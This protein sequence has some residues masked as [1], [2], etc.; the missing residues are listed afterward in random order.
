[1]TELASGTDLVE[2]CF[3]RGWTDGLPVAPPTR[4]RVDAML[5][6]HWNRRDEEVAVLEPSRG[7]ATLEHV[8]ANAVMAGCRPEHLPVVEA[9]VRACADPAFELDRVLTTASSQIP[10]L[11][12]SGPVVEEVG[13]DGGREALGSGA[14]ANA[15][16]GRALMLVLRNVA[17]LT[18]G[19]LPHSTLGHPGA[20]GWCVAENGADSPWP[21][22]HADDG[23]RADR[24]VVSVYPGE[25]PLVLV[26][27]G[28]DTA[29]AIIRTIATGMRTPSTYTAYFRQ[30]LWLVVSP[31]HARILAEG[32]IDRAGLQRALH[33]QARIPRE[34]L[35][36]RGLYG[37]LDD[38]HPPRWL[39]DEDPV[40]VVD[41]PER[42]HVAVA[43]GP[44]GGYTAVVFGE[45]RTVRREI[46]T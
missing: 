8:A 22:W 34:R 40:A 3:E 21:P 14:R 5:G 28:D 38:L 33:D 29:A 19:G 11:V 4:D 16:I 36:G 43:G 37:Y 7:V 35:V 39:D 41:S 46:A 18:A 26:E 42:I 27:M 17:S 24:S 10:F 2:V 45:G 13:L 44:F 30:D 12:V 15:T 25:P 9:A 20:R 6:D 32:G 1:M 23:L 31:Q